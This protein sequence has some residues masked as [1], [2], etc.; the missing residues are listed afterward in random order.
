MLE[1]DVIHPDSNLTPSS[2]TRKSIFELRVE[3]K[4]KVRALD[5]N[6]AQKIDP[7]ST[8]RTLLSN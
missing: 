5:T 3:V 6:Q 1:S 4:E 8:A 2:D 7:S